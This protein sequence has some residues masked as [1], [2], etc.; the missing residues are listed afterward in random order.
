MKYDAELR[1]AIHTN[2]QLYGYIFNDKKGRFKNGQYV[3]TSYVVKIDGNIYHTKNSTY[4]VDL[5]QDGRNG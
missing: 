4:L 5:T 3:M 2:G 1:S